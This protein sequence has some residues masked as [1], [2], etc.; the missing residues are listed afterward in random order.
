MCWTNL[1]PKEKFGIEDHVRYFLSLRTNVFLQIKQV[2]ITISFDGCPSQLNVESCDWPDINIL[3]NAKTCQI[4]S[5]HSAMN[6]K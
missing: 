2:L 4:S 6:N 3:V 1:S 5:N